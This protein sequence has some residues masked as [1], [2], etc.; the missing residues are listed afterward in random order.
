[1]ET[2]ISKLIIKSR[3]W[4]SCWRRKL[5][6][7]KRKKYT[8][9]SRRGGDSFWQVICDDVILL[10]FFLWPWGKIWLKIKIQEN[11]VSRWLFK[12]VYKIRSRLE[13]NWHGFWIKTY[14]FLDFCTFFFF[15]KTIIQ[16]YAFQMV[17]ILVV[18]FSS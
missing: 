4:W 14:L 17:T 10:F 6:P 8:L 11:L 2:I 1:M 12:F 7:W 15:E 18:C 3:I 13:S 16:H 5:S 9:S